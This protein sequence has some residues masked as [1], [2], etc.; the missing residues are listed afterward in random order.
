MCPSS[1]NHFII[2]TIH[3]H[4]NFKKLTQQ[5]TTKQSLAKIIQNQKKHLTQPI[6]KA[7]ITHFLN[8]IKEKYPYQNNMP[9][10]EIDSTQV[11]DHNQNNKKVNPR[12]FH[13]YTTVS[14]TPGEH[15]LP[16]LK[17]SGAVGV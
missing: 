9:T 6:S 11:L 8:I 3:R 14:A 7:C 5:A 12:K 13:L 1:T 17:W 4:Q 10:Q 16:P 2:G 15:L